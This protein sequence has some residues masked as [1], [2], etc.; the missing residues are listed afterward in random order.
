MLAIWYLLLLPL[1]NS[2]CTSGHSW[3]MNCWSLDFEHYLAS[4][5]NKHNRMAVWPFFGLA[6]LWTGMKIDHFQS[7]GYSWVFHIS[8]HLEY[9]TLIASSFIILNSSAGIPLPPLALFVVMIP[10]AYLTSHSRMSIK[11]SQLGKPVS[12]FWWAELGLLSLECKEV[13]WRAILTKLQS[14]RQCGTGSK[15]EIQTN[16]TK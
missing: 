14:S 13:L 4:M 2:A 16:G 1:Q 12:I 7:C 6:L 10:K 3:L 9:S 11:I 15:T 8:W 5:W